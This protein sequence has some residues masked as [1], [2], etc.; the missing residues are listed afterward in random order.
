MGLISTVKPDGPAIRLRRERLG[1]TQAD[2]AALVKR[3]R[4]TISDVERGRRG[5]SAILV[6]QIARALKADPES[7]IKTDVAA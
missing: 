7:F 1:L 3:H 2:L 5:V 4:Q 6:G